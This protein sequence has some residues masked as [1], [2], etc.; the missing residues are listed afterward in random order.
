[1]LTDLIVGDDG[2]PGHASSL[3]GGSFAGGSLS[4]ASL[5]GAGNVI[6]RSGAAGLLVSGSIS[7]QAAVRGNLLGTDASG[8]LA[9]PHT[10][11]GLPIALAAGSTAAAVVLGG[12]DTYD[13][14]TGRLS[15]LGGNVVAASGGIGILLTGRVAGGVSVQG[16]FVGTD[17]NGT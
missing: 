8:T 3:L 9:M 12:G 11:D 7:G 5:A 17:V 14:A 2:L 15:T 13:P 6:A 10:G 1:A 16:D 4:G